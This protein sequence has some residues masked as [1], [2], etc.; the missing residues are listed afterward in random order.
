MKECLH[1]N[2]SHICLHHGSLF[3]NRLF[4]HVKSNFKKVS[5]FLFSFQNVFYINLTLKQH[6]ISVQS[7]EKVWRKKTNFKYSILHTW[8]RNALDRSYSF[9]DC[10]P[11]KKQAKNQKTKMN[12]LVTFSSTD[13]PDPTVKN[14]KQRKTET[15]QRSIYGT[16]KCQSHMTEVE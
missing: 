9:S 12:D 1:E 3:H 10:L 2:P 15:Q 5:L 7:K 8:D 16:R 14:P 4:A 13:S 6:S 11:L